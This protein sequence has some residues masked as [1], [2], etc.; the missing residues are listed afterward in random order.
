MYSYI[1]FKYIEKEKTG[2]FS[3]SD[4]VTTEALQINN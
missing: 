2:K 4:F 1:F 3:A